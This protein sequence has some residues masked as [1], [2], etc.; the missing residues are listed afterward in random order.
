MEDS[1]KTQLED[2]ADNAGAR[3]AAINSNPKISQQEAENAAV[4]EGPNAA[5]GTAPS[6]SEQHVRGTSDPQATDIPTANNPNPE[7]SD[8]TDEVLS[9]STRD[10]Q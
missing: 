9:R 4:G 1:T 6:S 3:T 7:G 2:V 5:G 10:N 8:S